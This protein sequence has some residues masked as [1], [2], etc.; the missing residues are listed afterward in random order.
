MFPVHLLFIGITFLSFLTLGYSKI[1]QPYHT[2]LFDMA[3]SV[4]DVPKP[5][6]IVGTSHFGTVRY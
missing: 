5:S 2:N 4:P 1:G 3:V 6:S